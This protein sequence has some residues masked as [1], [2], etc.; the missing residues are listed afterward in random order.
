VAVGD[1]V[2][3]SG[4]TTALQRGSTVTLQALIGGQWVALTTTTVS[5]S[6]YSVSNTFGSTGRHTL[7]VVDGTTVSTSINVYVH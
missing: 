2:T 6:S 4:S 3:F 1:S 5:H 7:S